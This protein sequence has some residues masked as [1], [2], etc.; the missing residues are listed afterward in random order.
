MSWA[1]STSASFAC[2]HSSARS[3]DAARVLALLERTRE[4]LAYHFPQL[5]GELTVVLHDSPHALALS[6]PLMP[7]LWGVTGKTA[8]RYVAGWA[9]ERELHTL[10]PQALR[11]RASSVSGSFEILALAPASLYA[12]RVI[13]ESNRELQSARVVSRLWAELRWAWLLDG[14]SR[15]FSGETGYSRSVVG[16][17]IRAGHRPRFPP[18]ARDAPLLGG[19]LVELLAE[20][21]DDAAVARLAGRLHTG[22]SQTAL[23]VA[24][25]E[26]AVMT[27]ETEWRSRLRRLADGA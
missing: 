9:G 21:Q 19:T 5:T 22:G 17:Y 1:E 11:A 2:R 27:V 14:A 10:S 24:F 23:R 20:Q 15:W 7:A 4:R 3:A 16:Q 18:A 12:R 6:N 25:G 13:I 26:R 8:R